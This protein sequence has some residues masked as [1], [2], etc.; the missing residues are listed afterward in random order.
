M[1]LTNKEGSF[2]YENACEI[3]STDAIFD[4]GR[5]KAAIGKSGGANAS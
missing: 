3:S 1:H 2:L 5:A 4:D